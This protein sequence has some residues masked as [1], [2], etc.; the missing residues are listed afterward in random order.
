MTFSFYTKTPSELQPEDGFI[1]K[2]KHVANV[3]FQLS[4]NYTR[5]IYNK[6]FVG[7]YTYIYI[8]VYIYIHVGKSKI[9]RTHFFQFNYT[10][11][12]LNNYVILVHRL[13]PFRCTWSSG[14]EACMFPPRKRCSIC[15]R[16][17]LCTAFHTSL[18]V[19]NR[20]LRKA[21]LN[22]PKR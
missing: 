19:E 18:S 10:N 17:H 21:F 14:P 5:I 2:P 3:I 12:G 20:R 9:I 13:H 22:G 7:V 8:Y 11:I 6:C 15:L 16:N 4:F 1:K